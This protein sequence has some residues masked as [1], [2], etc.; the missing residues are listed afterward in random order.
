MLFM[1][2]MAQDQ[3]GEQVLL[4]EQGCVKEDAHMSWHVQMWHLLWTLGTVSLPEFF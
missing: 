4:G 1:L 2:T 3:L